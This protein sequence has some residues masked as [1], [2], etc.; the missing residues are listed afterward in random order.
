[1]PEEVA[2]R[3]LL[4]PYNLATDDLHTLGAND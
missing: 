4:A 3:L 2:A 1:M